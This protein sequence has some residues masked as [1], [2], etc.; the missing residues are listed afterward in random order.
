MNEKRKISALSIVLQPKNHEKAIALTDWLAE[1]S[2][3]PVWIPLMKSH[4]VIKAIA[5]LPT[6]EAYP[7]LLEALFQRMRYK[8]LIE[9]QNICYE[10]TGIEIKNYELYLLE[11]SIF[12]NDILPSTLG[13]AIHAL[14]FQWLA[15]A[16][17]NLAKDVH[18]REYSPITV[19]IKP[20]AQ[21]M[22]MTLKIGLLQGEL[23]APL[24]WGMSRDI[25]NEISITGV[26]CRLGNEIKICQT[27]SFKDLMQIAPQK[28]ICLEFLSPTS[29]KQKQTIQPFPLPQLVFSN[30]WR[31]WNN[32]APPEL[33]LPPVEWQILTSEF[34][35][36]TFAMKMKGGAEIGT[37]GWVKYHFLQDEQAKIATILAHFATFA[38]IGRK[39]AMGMGQV[40]L[41]QS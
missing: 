1:L 15:N 36:K 12:P 22:A 13:R 21:Q 26:T 3:F 25:G 14:C 5:V 28:K 18:N 2:P 4:G 40:K 27:S 16:S 20:K 24:L 17:P 6:S 32:S 11:I 7:S 37:K 29:F 34:E 41:I 30:L 9:F 8:T 23:L 38:G 33:Q 19:A 35:I 39:T 31:R 10:I